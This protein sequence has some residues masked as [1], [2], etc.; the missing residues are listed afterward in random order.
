M[1]W[2]AFIKPVSDLATL[3]AGLY[4]GSKQRGAIRTAGTT[5][6]NQYNT[7]AE[8]LL[9]VG[10]RAAG[11]ILNATD[12]AGQMVE[13]AAQGGADLLANNTNQGVQRIDDSL[14]LLNPYIG[15]GQ[16]GI[17]TINGGFDA[18]NDA[19]LNFL[20]GQGSKAINNT[21]SAQGLFGGNTGRALEQFGQGTA[22][23]YRTNWLNDQLKLVNTGKGAIDSRTAGQEDVAALLNKSGNDI[24]NLKYRGTSDAAGYKVGGV[25]DA[26]KYRYGS[27]SDAVDQWNGAASATASS[28]LGDANAFAQLLNG[29]V[30]SGGNF[31]QSLLTAI[32]G[33]GQD[34]SFAANNP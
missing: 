6:A 8:R 3:G 22:Q 16:K 12:Q 26:N 24:A 29:A 5:L 25:Q 30:K 18:D 28:Q 20:L 27:M 19:G 21:A 7:N 9:G 2:T 17:D 14:N 1:A 31:L 34:P 32:K 11:D 15:L 10:D 4:S 33:G 23:A 13:G